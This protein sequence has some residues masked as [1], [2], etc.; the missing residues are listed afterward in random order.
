MVIGLGWRGFLL[1]RISEYRPSS[2]ADLWMDLTR[3]F[4][5]LGKRYSESL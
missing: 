3:D 5:K 2:S 1:Y 4:H